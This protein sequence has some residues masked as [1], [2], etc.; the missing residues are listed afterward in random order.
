LTKT[1]SILILAAAFFS[2][3][4]FAGL[5][6]K[7][8]F[9]ILKKNGFRW[10]QTSLLKAQAEAQT[11]QAESSTKPLVFFSSREYLGRVNQIQF[12]FDNPGN[13][14]IFTLGSTGI[15]FF[16]SLIDTA[17]WSRIQASE[18]NEKRT[19]QQVRQYQNDL[20]YLMLLQ[21]LNAQRYKRK[22]QIAEENIQ[23]SEKIVHMAEVKM[24]SGLGLQLDF[25]RAKGL[26]QRDQLRQLDAKSNH[27]KALQDLAATLGI[28]K[29]TEDLPPLYPQV[30]NV[31][32]LNVNETDVVNHRPDVLSAHDAV[33]AARELKESS[34]L[35][36]YPKVS[37]FGDTGFVGTHV[38]GGFNHTLTGTVGVQLSLPLYTGGLFSAKTQERAVD[39]TKADLQ[40]KQLRL[41][42]K[43]QVQQAVEQLNQATQTIKGTKAQLEI[44]GEANRLAHLRFTVGASSGLEVSSSETEL[45]NAQ[46]MDVDALFASEVAKVNYFKAINDFPKYFELE[47]GSGP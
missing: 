28:E 36:A 44:A 46:D 35:E 34:R 22:L 18:Y 17:A 20:T 24:H 1:T 40:E 16:Q 13:Q 23:R 21:Y 5:D 38:I 3:P 39:E 29:I 8:A 41:E 9:E 11:A 6:K 37:I 2:N 12:G 30:L 4:A 31:E 14:S 10:R 47:S 32:T 43:S 7:T 33:N 27:D 15:V 19:E 45:A 26:A 42:A 25:M